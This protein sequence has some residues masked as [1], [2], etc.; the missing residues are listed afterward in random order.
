MKFLRIIQL[1]LLIAF[2]V[3]LFFVHRTNT[4]ILL[5]PV[6][7][8]SPGIALGVIFFLGYLIGMFPAQVGNWQKNRRIKK[9]EKQIEDLQLQAGIVTPKPTVIPDRSANNTSA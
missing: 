2:T 1:V 9:L 6:V 5:P 3:Y 4:N 7:P 8:I